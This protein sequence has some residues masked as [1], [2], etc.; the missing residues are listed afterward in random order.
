MA[1]ILHY[2]TRLPGN[3]TDVFNMFVYSKLKIELQLH[4]HPMALIKKDA[5]DENKQSESLALD[6]DSG[7]VIGI[8]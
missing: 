2:F 1:E 4:H 7:P 8:K 5:E 3:L 6:C